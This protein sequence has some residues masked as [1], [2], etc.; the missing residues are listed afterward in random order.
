M[1][2]PDSRGE[3][4]DMI[5]LYADEDKKT[6]VYALVPPVNAGDATY[7]L[8]LY[9]KKQWTTAG[10]IDGIVKTPTPAPDL[11]AFTATG[12]RSKYERH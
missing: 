4:P 6:V 1:K 2:P 10:Y 8:R 9:H 11:Y 7:L 12:R 5:Y 3:L